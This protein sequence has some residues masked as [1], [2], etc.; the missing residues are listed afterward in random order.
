M[1][2]Y[3]HR[4]INPNSMRSFFDF[5]LASNEWVIFTIYEIFYIEYLDDVDVRF[6]AL[7]RSI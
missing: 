7:E 6:R 1:A 3:N 2:K 4:S 5:T